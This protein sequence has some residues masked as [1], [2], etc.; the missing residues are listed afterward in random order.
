MQNLSELLR[1]LILAEVEFV[2]VGGFAA[3]SHGVTLVTRDVDICCRFSEAN[4]MRIQEAF[5]DLHPVHRLRPDLPL[6]LTP[7]Q[8]VT[9]KN[10]YV[11]TDLGIVDCLGEIL[12]VGGFEKVLKDSIEVT[13]PFGKCRILA[14]DALIRAKEAMNRDH[15]IIT[16]KHLKVIKAQIKS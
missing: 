10:L 6:Q 9:L 11:K 15:D 13:L 1:R 12:G 7:E 4:L 3:V 16:V 14:I 5:K 8:C 2:L